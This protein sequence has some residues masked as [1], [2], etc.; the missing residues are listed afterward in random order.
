MVSPV[1]V[2]QVTFDAGVVLVAVAVDDLVVEA[3][4]EGDAVTGAAGDLG[5]SDAGLDPER[6]RRTTLFKGSSGCGCVTRGA[7]RR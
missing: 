7:R 5:R 1:G 2:G 6:G 3:V 4:E